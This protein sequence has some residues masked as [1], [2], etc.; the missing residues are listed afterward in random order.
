MQLYPGGPLVMNYSK[1]LFSAS[2]IIS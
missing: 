1:Q 2:D